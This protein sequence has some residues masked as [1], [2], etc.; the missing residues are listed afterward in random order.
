MIIIKECLF[1]FYYL[2]NKRPE[3][4]NNI[5][6]NYTSLMEIKITNFNSK[7]IMDMSAT[8]YYCTSLKA[9]PVI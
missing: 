3:K 5:F 2:R 7:N 9:L 6:N 1:R 8:F 4:S